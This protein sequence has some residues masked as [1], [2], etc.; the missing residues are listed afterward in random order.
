[1]S[2]IK[3]HA[4]ITAEALRERHLSGLVTLYSLPAAQESVVLRIAA[5][6]GGEPI[7]GEKYIVEFIDADTGSVIEVQEEDV[8][9]LLDMDSIRNVMDDLGESYLLSIAS[10][11]ENYVQQS[12][13]CSP[14]DGGPSVYERSDIEQLVIRG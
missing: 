6:N 13:R 5:P 1:M 7:E 11:W 12:G 14:E 8:T 9:R 10:A 2:D 4:S 3:T